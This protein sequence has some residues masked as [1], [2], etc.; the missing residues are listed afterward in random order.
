MKPKRGMKGMMKRGERGR[1]GM[2]EG[3]GYPEP[4]GLG[5]LAGYEKVASAPARVSVYKKKKGRGK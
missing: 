5:R 4:K 3:K 1:G 2:E